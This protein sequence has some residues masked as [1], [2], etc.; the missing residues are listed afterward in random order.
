MDWWQWMVVGGLLLGAELVGLEAQFYLL[1]I[2][3]SAVL[4]GLADLV[5]MNM[6]LWAQVGLFGVL[7]LAFLYAFRKN[8]YEKIRSPG[9]GFGDSY[10][11]KSLTIVSELAS[12]AEAR[13]KYRG[14]EWTARNVGES[15]IAAGSRAKIRKVDGLT[16]HIE[17]E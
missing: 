9:G 8:M 4:V 5:G 6:P 16:L 13:L 17:A 11:G 10:G 1:F 7:S 2:G 3:L 15:T 14:S 12:G